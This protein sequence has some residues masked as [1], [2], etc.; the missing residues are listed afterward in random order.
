MQPR[1]T[2]DMDLEYWSELNPQPMTFT[3]PGEQE[4]GVKPCG[5]IVTDDQM[6]NEFGKVAR[7]PWTLDDDEIARLAGGGT[8]WLSCWGGLPM[9]M[10]EVSDA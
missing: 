10:L 1:P 2:N 6:G 7:V 8:L 5:A 9:H 3:G 4:Q